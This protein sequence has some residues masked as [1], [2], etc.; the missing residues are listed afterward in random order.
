MERHLEVEYDGKRY[1]LE[2]D[3]G[4]TTAGNVPKAG[5]QP[6]WRVTMSGTAITS[7]EARPDESDDDARS[8]LRAWLDREPDLNNRDQIHL[9]GG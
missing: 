8:R 9:G 3:Y 6:M 7:F 2:L 1:E 5:V 4:Q